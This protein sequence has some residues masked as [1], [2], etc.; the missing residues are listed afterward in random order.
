MAAVTVVMPYWNAQ[1]TVGHAVESIRQQTFTDWKLIVVVDGC[2]PP[3]L[4][5]DSRIHVV[6]LDT[7]RGFANALAEGL[8]LTESEYWMGHDADDWSE[9]SRFQHL[10]DIGG[11]VLAPAIEHTRRGVTR[12][13]PVELGNA[14]GP[15]RHVA[16]YQA[17]LYTTETAR[18]VGWRRDV[19][20]AYDSVFVGL[21]VKHHPFTVTDKPQ[22]H[23]VRRAGSLTTRRQ[24]ERFQA[25]RK[26]CA[27]EWQRRS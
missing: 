5:R 10:L 20:Y 6:Q 15:L 21:V 19:R 11:N 1:R 14:A 23:L 22:Y 24:S 3:E 18:K 16:W 17:G 26:K 12:V 8:A 13:R 4:R 25:D 2:E 9:P 7:N 27:E